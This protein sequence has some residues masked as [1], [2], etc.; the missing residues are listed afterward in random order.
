MHK[1]FNKTGL[2]LLVA[3]AQPLLSHGG[4]NAGMALIPGG[5]FFIGK[6][7]AGDGSPRH[8]VVVDSFYIDV[9]EVTNADY[10]QFCRAT[11]HPLPEFW[12]MAAFHSGD[13]F[14]NFPVVGVSWFDA[15][16]FA[17]WAGKRLP[18]EAEWEIAARGGLL[19]MNFPN[20]NDIDT[21][22]ANITVNGQRIGA[23][24]VGCYSA[25]N[26]GLY[27]MA[28][29]VVEWVADCY[30]ENYYQSS[31]REN[32]TGPTGGRFKVIRGGG[33]HS[34]PSCNQVFYRN[35]LPANWVDIAVG[36]R[37]AKSVSTSR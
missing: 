2:L 27:D 14:A 34:G 20:G 9:H 12:G 8:A 1:F 22:R 7:G 33:W 35:A 15:K 23:R 31:Q 4:T 26:Y 25:N 36:F 29:N 3:C 13:E 10:A 24:P 6:E 18:T 11:N 28:G 21:S 37:C 17:E 32:P 16:A 5:E 19:D 30:G